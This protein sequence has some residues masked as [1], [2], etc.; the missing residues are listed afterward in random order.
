AP[1]LPQDMQLADPGTR[2]T[3]MHAIQCCIP[4]ATLLPQ[5][6]ERLYLS[7]RG[8]QES[9]YV[10]LDARERSQDGDSY[11]YDLDVRDPDGVLVER[12]EGLTL[13][14]VRKR[15]GAGPWVPSMLGPDLLDLRDLLVAEAGDSPAVA[16]TRAWSA[17][18]CVRKTGS[19][20]QVLTARRVDDDG[21]VLLSGGEARIATWVTT[22]NDRP[23]PVVFAVL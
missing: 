10:V 19:M 17:L 11:V 7:G 4:D 20:T 9:A 2:D 3:M 8:D 23:D 16:A 18:E 21:W 12:W 5:R 22:V 15:N 13:R 1:F 6:I 14:A